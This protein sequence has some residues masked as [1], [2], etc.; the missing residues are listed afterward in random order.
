MNAIV[1]LDV[2]GVVDP[3]IVRGGSNFGDAL[4]FVIDPGIAECIRR[5][6]NAA[7]IVWLTA[8]PYDQVAHLSAQIEVES[9][10]I[11]LSEP[12][13]FY[14]AD[15]IKTQKIDRWLNLRSTFEN[16]HWSALVWVDDNLGSHESNWAKSQILPTL[17]VPI[18]DL[19]KFSIKHVQSIET[20]CE[21]IP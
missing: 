11:S 8:W 3:K 20:F 5:T 12:K 2:D 1:F 7:D 9:R 16:L 4:E 17:L 18:G 13:S 14:S 21:G 10:I 15:S 6:A 19:D